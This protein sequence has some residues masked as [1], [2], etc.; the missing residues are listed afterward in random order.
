VVWAPRC[1]GALEAMEARCV[2]ASSDGIFGGQVA[3][4][5]S[6]AVENSGSASPL[7]CSYRDCSAWQR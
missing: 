3:L 7:A 5:A 6:P 1:S 4:A 2:D